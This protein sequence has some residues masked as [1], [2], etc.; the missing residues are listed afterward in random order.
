ME[1]MNKAF[2]TE[3]MDTGDRNCPR[4]GSLGVPVPAETLR[5]HLLPDALRNLSE[6]AYFCPFARCEVAYFDMFER[7]VQVELLARP[8]WPKDVDAPLCGCFGLTCDDVEDD[9]R[10]GTPTRVRALLARSKS[11]EARCTIMAADGRCCMPQV[12]R[13]YMKRRQE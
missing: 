7:I 10:E 13:Y 3:P 5:E 1:A 9:L 6:T 2:I 4:C 12:Q 8:V 11:P